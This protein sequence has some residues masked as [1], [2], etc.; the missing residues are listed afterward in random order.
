[1]LPLSTRSMQSG[2]WAAVVLAIAALL[3]PR[4]AAATETFEVCGVGRV[5]V[6]E[7][8]RLPPMATPA[9]DALL[10]RLAS[11]DKA[12]ERAIGLVNRHAV[13][14]GR[15]RHSALASCRAGPQCEKDAHAAAQAA[16]A[17]DAALLRAHALQSRDRT[18][19]ALA[20][21]L[22]DWTNW[23]EQACQAQAATLWVEVDQD[24]V[25]A[26]LALAGASAGAPGRFDA[27]LAGAANARRAEHYY[28]RRTVT[29]G[30]E[31]T[32]FDQLSVIDFAANATV[33]LDYGALIEG[34]SA[35]ALQDPLRRAQC[36]NILT[37]LAEQD[38]TFRGRSLA[39][40][41]GAHRLGWPAQRQDRLRALMN[42]E[43]E[44]VERVG[45]E[46]LLS[47][48]ATQEMY[49]HLLDVD[50]YGEIEAARLRVER[51]GLS[52][53]ELAAAQK[54]RRAQQLLN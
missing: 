17:A 18:A 22:C 27:A 54:R 11:S 44:L 47:C 24:N 35:K 40:G 50:R 42:A 41:I 23:R 16:G 52:I 26:W 25:L 6:D 3:A 45:R 38:T 53:D 5:P 10:D 2:A 36:Q 43:V 34:C 30:P 21:H 49:R 9:L 29:L 48:N 12:D 31:A 14:I 15:A 13:T 39:L 46:N 20:L 1:M 51:S 7:L 19:R 33:F 8:G 28:Q 37:V 32:P 4:A